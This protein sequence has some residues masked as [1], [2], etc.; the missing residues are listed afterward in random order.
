MISNI[1]S[2]S[3]SGRP[4]Q[5]G[6]R[7]SASR[8]EARKPEGRND[9]RHARAVLRQSPPSPR[10]AR[11]A[12]RDRARVARAERASVTARRAD[13]D[14]KR[15]SALLLRAL[16]RTHRRAAASC[17][18]ARPRTGRVPGCC[19]R[20]RRPAARPRARRRSWLS[21]G[22]QRR[23]RPPLCGFACVTRTPTPRSEHAA[24][25]R[26]QLLRHKRA[27]GT[28]G[29]ADCCCTGNSATPSWPFSRAR[30]SAA[31]GTLAAVCVACP[32]A[33]DGDKR[34]VP[35]C[36][37][38]VRLWPPAMAATQAGEG[39]CVRKLRLPQEERRLALRLS[40]WSLCKMANCT[41]N[42]VRRMRQ[43][44][45]VA[46][47]RCAAACVLSSCAHPADAAAV[48]AA[49]GPVGGTQHGAH[50]SDRRLQ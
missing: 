37:Q 35:F 5:S 9:E 18:R 41:S 29:Q 19:A 47:R 34:A 1:C 28:L 27:E 26:A 2:S 13:G 44:V 21:D 40:L 16:L 14:S 38:S 36:S 20:A 39:G 31:S 48:C 6:Y 42:R 24:A 7:A 49:A 32:A 33:R 10:R 11:G 45:S 25:T 17:A 23:V 8:V 4:A 22:T 12:T 46:R 43:Q 3:P 15:T 30:P 50:I